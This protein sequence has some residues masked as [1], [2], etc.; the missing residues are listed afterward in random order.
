VRGKVPLYIEI[1]NGNRPGRLE[2][3]VHKLLRSYHA[4]YAKH[5]GS[6]AVASFNPLVLAWFRL[7]APDFLRVQIIGNSGKGGLRPHEKILARGWPLAALGQPHALAAA[8]PILNSPLVGAQR[9][10]GKP[11]IAWTVRSQAHLQRALRLADAYVFE[12]LRP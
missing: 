12:G 4:K 11:I 9:S 10:L 8:L 7:K 3:E 5:G 6:F 1:K 2:Q